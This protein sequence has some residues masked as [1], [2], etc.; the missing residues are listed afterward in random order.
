MSGMRPISL[1][2]FAAGGE[3]LKSEGSYNA[4][5]VRLPQPV[6]GR[7]VVTYSKPEEGRKWNYTSPYFFLSPDSEYVPEEGAKPFK[8]IPFDEGNPLCFPLYYLST[9]GIIEQTVTHLR[10]IFV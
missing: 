5:D 6:R 8:E 3:E 10:L 1:G 2:E 7:A 4:Y 9:I